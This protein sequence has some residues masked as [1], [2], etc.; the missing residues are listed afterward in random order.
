MF[1]RSS[2]EN[3]VLSTVNYIAKSSKLREQSKIQATGEAGR[4]THSYGVEK[5][6]RIQGRIQGQTV[7][8]IGQQQ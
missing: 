2:F 7:A 1:E 8:W 4:L 5:P 3:K 6:G